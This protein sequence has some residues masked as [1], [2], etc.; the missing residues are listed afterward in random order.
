[1]FSSLV[2]INIIFIP[3]WDDIGYNFLIGG[4]GRVYE[5][6]SWNRVGA[7]TKGYNKNGIAFSL[8]GDYSNKV[9]NDLMLNTTKKMIE[10][11]KTQ[12]NI[13]FLY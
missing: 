2:Q 11:A 9:P 4:N 5:G 6:R 12:V 7:H 3:G 8:M 13:S 1:M 10:C